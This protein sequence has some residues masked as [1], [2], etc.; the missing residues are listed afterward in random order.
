M[1]LEW[2][3]EYITEFPEVDQQHKHL[4]RLAGVLAMDIL[5]GQPSSV[6]HADLVRIGQS[7]HE[8]IATE[9]Q[10][11]D[12]HHCHSH[13]R[14]EHSSDHATFLQQ[15][16]AVTRENVTTDEARAF[17]RYSIFWM[18]YHVLAVD[19]PVFA[20]MKAISDGKTPKE[21]CIVA[22]NVVRDVAPVLLDGV[23][24]TYTELYDTQLHIAKQNHNLRLIQHELQMSNQALEARVE[25]RTNELSDANNKL[26]DEYH[27]LQELNQRLESAQGQ[28]LQSDKMA[29]IGQLAAGVA[30]EINNPIGFVN[31][32]L[33]SLKNYIESLLSLITLFEQV[34]DELPPAVRNHVIEAAQKMDLDY[35]RQDVLD[36]LN[37]STDGLDR[38]KQIV[39]DLKDFARAG[40]AVWQDADLHR[41]LDSTLNVVWNEVKY[42]A[43]VQKN[44]GDLPLVRC[45]PAQINQVFMNILVNAAHAIENMGEIIIRTGVEGDDVWVSI[46]DSGKGMSEEVQ[47]RIFEPFYTTKPLGK[48]TGLGLSLAYGIIQKHKGRIVVQ[49][50]E[51]K[52]STFTVYLP[53]H[54]IDEVEALVAKGK[55]SASSTQ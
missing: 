25:Q 22:S 24:K 13:L 46:T 51:G 17:L 50:E 47:K 8:H 26:Q 9:E 53:I 14:E 39:Q 40:E 41:G 43:Q 35:I 52:G 55:A 1:A 31:A 29:A 15:I 18:R 32:N 45:V 20:H 11:M 30:H 28:L 4:F 38:V 36:L 6:L 54:G 7:F 21:A 19:K 49:S 2:K 5:Q 16:D 12:E 48:G 42:K 10:L 27:K 33:G 44:Y 23:G 3:E 37:E 34:A